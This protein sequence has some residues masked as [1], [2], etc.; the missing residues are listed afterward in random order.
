LATF[1]PRDLPNGLNECERKIFTLLKRLLFKP[2][3]LLCFRSKLKF[4]EFVMRSVFKNVPRQPQKSTV[5]NTLEQMKS[6]W[7]YYTV[8]LEDES[9]K[10]GMYADN[11]PFPPRMMQRKVNFTQTDC[12][13]I[14]SAEGLLPILASKGGACSVVTTDYDSAHLDKLN[15]LSAI[16]QVETAFHELGQAAK[17]ETIR[18]KYPTGFDY[19]NISGLL[20][21]VL[22]PIDVLAAAR[23]FLRPGGLMLVS[24]ILTVNK[25][26]VMEFNDHGR[27]Q[28]HWNVFWYLS[29]GFYEYM[30]RML[31]LNP[32]DMIY[33]GDDKMGYAS[34]LCRATEAPVAIGKDSFMQSALTHSMEFN[35]LRNA[36]MH[37]LPQSN[38]GLK[39]HMARSNIV[40]YPG[41]DTVDMYET[42]RKY[43]SIDTIEKTQESRLFLLTDRE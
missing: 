21:H 18:K 37:K 16:H 14:G 2:C 23:S 39:P 35:D 5:E 25:Q 31:Q 33:L 15:Y 12:L 3:F 43:G 38:I 36:A 40:T 30:L 28:D 20:Y 29:A 6:A 24:T 1:F 17:L 27:F 26:C 19:I 8:Q 4:K 7:W 42:I 34:V 22:S 41:T 11:Y 9:I 13:D 10:K 32:I